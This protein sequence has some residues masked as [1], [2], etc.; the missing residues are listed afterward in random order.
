MSTELDNKLDY[1]DNT[2]QLIKQAI[3]NKRSN[4]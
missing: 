4:H 1:L 3:I 2:K